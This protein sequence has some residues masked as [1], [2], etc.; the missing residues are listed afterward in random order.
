M[1]FALKVHGAR[2]GARL[3]HFLRESHLI[4]NLEPI[5]V[6]IDHAVAV[7]VDVPTIGR[8]N[9]AV[10]LLGHEPNNAPVRGYLMCLHVAATAALVVFQ[11]ASDG[12]ERIPNSDVHIL[13][14]LMFGRIPARDQL[15]VGHPHI[16]PD[17]V[18]VT[19]VVMFVVCLDDHTTADNLL[20]EMLELLR[21]LSN[22]GFNGVGVIEIT[23]YDL[24]R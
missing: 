23:K 13:M 8:F 20:G 21:A 16:H 6:G 4:A 18:Q 12:I 10:I 19:F 1:V 24:Q 9:L 14:R 22:L 5:E 11:L 3:T 15:M 7:K 2:L 17:M